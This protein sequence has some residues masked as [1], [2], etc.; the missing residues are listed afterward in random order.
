MREDTLNLSILETIADIHR[1]L[2]CVHSPIQ[3]LPQVSYEG[4]TMII[5]WVDFV[6][7]ILISPFH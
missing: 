3:S 2:V 5:T 1:A 7:P 6:C 4:G